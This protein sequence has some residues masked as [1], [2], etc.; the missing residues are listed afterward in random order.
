MILLTEHQF[1]I[2]EGFYS[3]LGTAVSLFGLVTNA[4]NIYTFVAMG[5]DDGVT[6]SFLF[7]SAAEFVCFLAALGQ[8]VSMIFW[9]IEMITGYRTVFSIQP[10]AA[11]GF[12]GNIRNCLFTIPVLI[13]LYL[14]VAKCACVVRPLHFKNMFSVRRTVAVMTGI[15]VFAV[16][17]YLPIFPTLGVIVDLDPFINQ[18]RPVLYISP[19]LDIIKNVVWNARDSVPSFASQIIIIVCIFLMAHTLSRAASFRQSTKAARI[20]TDAADSGVLVLKSSARL[21][22]TEL[23]VIKQVA[24]ISVIYIIGNTPKIL[25]FIAFILF[26][27]LTQHHQFLTIAMANSRELI[28]MIMSAVNIIIYYKYNSKFRSFCKF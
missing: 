28:E 24:V 4:I 19:Y 25:E 27:D 16:L 21:S 20:T 13:T 15:C 7:L 2:I 5:A 26:P 11:N 3:T 8:E 22:G 10:M 23:Q 18:T 17:S 9:F 12:F 14:A 6:V 1:A